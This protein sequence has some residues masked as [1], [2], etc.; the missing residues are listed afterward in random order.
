MLGV[1]DL[2]IRVIVEELGVRILRYEPNY[3]ARASRDLDAIEVVPVKDQVHV[4]FIDAVLDPRLLVSVMAST[5]R[6]PQST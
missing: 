4:R 3:I 2:P 6:T 5:S 1:A